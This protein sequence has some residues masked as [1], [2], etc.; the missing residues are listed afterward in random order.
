MNNTARYH[1]IF[2]SSAMNIAFRI[3]PAALPVVFVLIS[4]PVRGSAGG[5]NP[6]S[7]G[8]EVQFLSGTDK[9]HTVDWDFYCTGG[10]K[11][12]EWTTI[13]VPSCWE[14]Q[15]F[16]TYNY[17]RDY[18][19]YG[20]RFQFADE[21]GRYRY[22]FSVPDSWKDR[23]VRLVFEGSMTDTEVMV[24]GHPAGAIHQGSFYRFSYPVSDLLEFG[25][26]NL[27]EVTV[28]KMSS[29]H[30]V[31]RAE[32]YADYWIFGGIFRPVYL[33]AFPV[34]HLSHVTVWGDADGTFHAVAAVENASPGSVVNASVMAPDGSVAGRCQA[35]VKQGDSLVMLKTGIDDPLLWTSETPVLYRAVFNLETNG[36]PDHTTSEVFGFRTVE[37]RHGDGIYLNGTKIKMKGINR[38][39]F[40]PETGRTLSREVDRLDIR[41]MKEMNMN[42]VRCSHYPPD[43]SF[44]EICD[45]MGMYVLDELAGWQN[46]YN[47]RV[48]TVL[49]KEM[50]LR[51]VNHPSIIFWSNGNEGGT[52][53][54]L[55]DDFLLHDPTGRRVIHAHHRPGHDFNGI[56][57]NHYESYQSMSHILQDSLIYMCTEFL[58]SQNDGGGGTGLRDYWDLMYASEK[59]GGG[60]IWALLDE[61]VVRTDQGGAIDVNLVN[62]PDGVLGPHREKEGSYGAIREVFCPVVIRPEELPEEF[63]GTL[64]VENRYFFNNLDQCRFEW[65]LLEF[66]APAD[67][68]SGH[69]VKDQGFLSGPALA[70]GMKGTLKIPLPENWQSSGALAL[71]AFDPSGREIMTW[72]WKTGRGTAWLHDDLAASDEDPEVA[73]REE[74]STITLSANDI[75]ISIDETT[76]MLSG[77]RNNGR[78]PISFGNGPV[79]CTGGFTV[80][81]LKHFRDGKNYVVESV[82]SGNMDRIRWTMMPGGWVRLDYSY[83]LSGE[84]PFA[85][86]SFDFEEGY[87]M[88]AR[89]LGDGPYRVWKNRMAGGSLDVWEKAYNNTMAGMYPWNFPEFKGYYDKVQW[90]ELNTLDGRILIA[91]PDQNLF[92]RLFEF[93]AFPAP[94][95]APDL[96]PGD[97][98][99]LDAIP[100]I[101]TKMSTRL[102]AKAG[103]T[104][105]RGRLNELDG[106][107]SHTLYFNFGILP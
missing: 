1:R 92:V 44:L 91:G 103:S 75:S 38:H 20:R 106:S 17:G 2:R 12:G 99:F 51:D 28:S 29:D 16:G 42:A 77:V 97:L 7:P 66:P 34:R 85:G 68:L 82:C 79:A 93:Y 74:D 40:W 89:W 6:P 36:H 100:P 35:A 30:S 84:Y 8:S 95:R 21:Q 96:P 39:A 31:N 60:F 13:A 53:P 43:P 25:R 4:G 14:Q 3:I 80:E 47:T 59:S 67:R 62:A 105:P 37:I 45:S 22:R 70:P 19:T 101:G 94:T 46:A 48:G 98:S 72:T 69:T 23:V 78:R 107:F 55:D 26:E 71:K 15:G 57:T 102:N 65:Q 11:S 18:V 63:D 73:F 61:G 86:I 64:P 52:N 32:R 5:E 81:G 10:R 24:N 58:H 56:E 27:L 41:M 104:G 49:V 50:V 33:E 88:S 76:G 90:I 87:V 83:S 54:E 9:D